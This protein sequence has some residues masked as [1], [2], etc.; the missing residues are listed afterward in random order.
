MSLSIV[1]LCS[2][3]FNERGREGGREGNINVRLP[4]MHPLLGPLPA[5]QAC[6]LTGNQTDDPLVHRLA[7]NPLSHP[8]QGRLVF[9]IFLLLE[10]RWLILLICLIKSTAKNI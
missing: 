1:D 6:A 3:H 8:S 2:I 10:L 4:L 9:L 5:T 7:L